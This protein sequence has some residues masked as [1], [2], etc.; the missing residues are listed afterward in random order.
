MNDLQVEI[1]CPQNQ[2]ELLGELL[3]LFG[4]G[5]IGERRGKR[6][7]GL[8]DLRD[9]APIVADWIAPNIQPQNCAVFVFAF[10]VLA[11]REF[12]ANCGLEQSGID[13]LMTSSKKLCQRLA[14][15]LRGAVP[16]KSFGTATPAL[17]SAVQSKG[18]QRLVR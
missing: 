16:V 6:S 11:M 17:N 9:L 14:L 2:R 5:S 4:I 10:G 3:E 18:Q 1:R 13:R 15:H 8:K 12:S 7:A